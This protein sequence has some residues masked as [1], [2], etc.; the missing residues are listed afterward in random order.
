MGPKA[1]K[2]IAEGQHALLD[3][4]AHILTELRAQRVT[5]ARICAKL[6]IEIEDRSEADDRLGARMVEHERE[7]NRLKLANG[8]SAE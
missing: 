2:V 8:Q 6:E 5:L 1:H 3:V 7:I 4:Q